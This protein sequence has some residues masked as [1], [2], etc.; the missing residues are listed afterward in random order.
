MIENSLKEGIYNHVSM[1]RYPITA[2]QVAC[3][4]G[5]SH[6]KAKVLLE[7]LWHEGR[8]T[9]TPYHT[10]KGYGMKKTIE[11]YNNHCKKSSKSPRYENEINI[12]IIV[13]KR[14]NIVE[15]TVEKESCKNKFASLIYNIIYAYFS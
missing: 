8:I 5:I 2:S 1:M 7:Q 11:N 15:F 14:E 13:E 10:R 6:Q 3:A 4:M 9:W 12:E